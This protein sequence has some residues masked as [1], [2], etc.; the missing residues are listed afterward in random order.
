M[1]LMQ[2]ISVFFSEKF[3]ERNKQKIKEM[4]EDGSLR[5]FAKT[6]I[7]KARIKHTSLFDLDSNYFNEKEYP[8]TTDDMNTMNRSEQMFKSKSS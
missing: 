3:D 5:K 6:R 2:S 4:V 7:Y 1:P 8:V